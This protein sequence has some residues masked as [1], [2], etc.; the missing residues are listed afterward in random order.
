M[1]LKPS[2]EMFS[3]VS[4]MANCAMF[5]KAEHI[6]VTGIKENMGLLY[7]L[8]TLDAFWHIVHKNRNGYTL[9]ERYKKKVQLGRI[10]FFDKMEQVAGGLNVYKLCLNRRVGA[11]WRCPP[12][13][14]L[15]RALVFIALM[16]S[17][18]LSKVSP[19]TIS[20]ISSYK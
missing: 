15:L 7:N 1:E 17:S 18:A 13:L 5:C 12:P 11:Q 4:V 8:E 14:F 3:V 19:G 20:G 6:K 10:Y 9:L 2:I 16:R